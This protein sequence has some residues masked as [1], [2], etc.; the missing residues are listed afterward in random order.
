MSD[1]RNRTNEIMELCHKENKPIFITRNGHGDM[2]VMSLAHYE[3]V[4][5]RLELY[6]KLSEAELLD[7]EGQ[8]GLTHEEMMADLRV[9]IA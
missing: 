7:V 4:M 1:L 9:R 2:V 5:Q 8:S 6:E 3:Q